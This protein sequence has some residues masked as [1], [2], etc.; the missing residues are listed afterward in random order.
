A[1]AK[2]IGVSVVAEGVETAEQLAML[3][4]M[5]CEYAQGYYF[6]EPVEHERATE[7]IGKSYND[8]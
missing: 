7:L 8:G 2:N 3:K 1:L 5:E 4:D 6:S